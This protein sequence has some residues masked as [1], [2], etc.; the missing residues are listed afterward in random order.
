MDTFASLALATDKPI[1]FLMQ[2][3]PFRENERILNGNI[4]KNIL[5]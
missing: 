2:R 1:P 4:F 3:G 5:F